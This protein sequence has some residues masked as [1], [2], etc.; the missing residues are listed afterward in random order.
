MPRARLERG[1]TVPGA[2]IIGTT[3]ITCPLCGV[4]ASETMPQD[5][6]QFFY[7]CSGCGAML[8]PKQ[9]DCCVFCSYGSVPCPPIQAERA[10]GDAPGC[11]GPGHGDSTP[12]GQPAVALRPGVRL[13]NW[14]VVSAPRALAALAENL[15]VTGKMARF[16]ELATTADAVWRRLLHL[17]VELG[18]AP[19]IDQ[20]D[21]SIDLPRDDVVAAVADLAARDI[22][23]RDAAGRIVGAYPFSEMATGHFVSIGGR[24]LN[25]MCAIDALGVGAMFGR[26]TAIASSC[27][28]C[29]GAIHIATADQ[30]RAIAGLVPGD[31]VVWASTAYESCA[32]DTLC[33]ATGFFCHDDHLAAWRIA[34]GVAPRGCRLSVDEALQ[35]AGAIFV[36][37]LAD[38]P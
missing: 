6:C 34:E 31:P 19:S 13:P 17:H 28:R 30:G 23:V 8:R 15:V 27:R 33:R 1:V 12:D 38:G 10:G 24:V 25:A 18:R 37:F 20:I 3:R 26:D 7:E 11:C 5:A 35:F 4:A 21:A 36:P 16:A 32:A 22:I 2:E 29:G 9:G 14:R